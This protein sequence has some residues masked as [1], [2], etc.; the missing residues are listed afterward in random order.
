MK[1]EV[2]GSC[3]SVLIPGINC[4]VRLAS[5]YGYIVYRCKCGAEKHVMYREATSKG[6]DS[7]T[8][9]DRIGKSDKN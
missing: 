7:T 1:T 6:F 3:D 2:C 5:S 4:S 9:F 8:A